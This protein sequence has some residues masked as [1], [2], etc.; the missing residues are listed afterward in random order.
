MSLA[1]GILQHERQPVLGVAY[2]HNLCILRLCKPLRRLDAFP[3]QKLLADALRR[4]SCLLAR[5]TNPQHGMDSI[6]LGQL[7]S[8]GC[9]VATGTHAQA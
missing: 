9:S 4:R 8:V 7:R 5:H 3:L 2:D 1:L 6:L